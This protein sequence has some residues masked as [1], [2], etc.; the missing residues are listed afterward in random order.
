MCRF[1][2]R[3]RRYRSERTTNKPTSRVGAFSVCC[4]TFW[5]LKCEMQLPVRFRY[6]YTTSVLCVYHTY[7]ARVPYPFGRK[8]KGHLVFMFMI[9]RSLYSAHR[10]G[11]CTLCAFVIV[12]TRCTY[13]VGW[14]CGFQCLVGVSQN[15]CTYTGQN[16]QTSTVSRCTVHVCRHAGMSYTRGYEECN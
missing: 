12:D 7:D 5:C 8:Y 9:K 14:V 13:H 6:V 4:S 3:R 15:Y 10:L 2:I 1:P 16:Q 11:I